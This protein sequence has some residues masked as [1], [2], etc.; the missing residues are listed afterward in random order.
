MSVVTYAAKLSKFS[1]FYKRYTPRQYMMAA[2]LALAMAAMLALGFM[3]GRN[4]A[5]AALRDCGE[6]VGGVH[7]SIANNPDSGGGCGA[8]S[9]E[10]LITDI[11][12][13]NP[14]DQAGVMA[15]FGL[16]SSSYDR[17]KNEAVMG[18]AKMNGDIV[19]DDEV[20]MKNAWS[21]GR[22]QFSYSQPYPIDGVGSYFKSAHT[23]VLQNEVPVMVLFDGSGAVETAVLTSCG[24]P[25]MGE[26]VISSAE[27]KDLR[28]VPVKE[29]ENTYSFTTDVNTEGLADIVKVEYFA[30]DEKFAEE[31]NPAT[32]VTKTFTENATVEARV[33]V[34]FPGGATKV[35]PSELCKE[36]V[37]VKKPEIKPAAVEKPKPQ[38]PKVEAVKVEEKLPVT[39]PES[40]LGIF[41]GTSLA[42]AIGH[43]LYTILRRK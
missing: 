24:N 39:G 17:F 34:R 35:L 37:E 4:S 20:V 14:D 6:E 26:K 3:I 27:C 33:T 11:N 5:A 21:I 32:P 2:I 18:V 31:E 40:A 9:P 36:V 43:R 10:E 23:D 38:Q 8:L 13:G 42:G 30:N 12:N 15:H 28:K 25:V 16:P 29:K 7:N 22:V 1:K 41:V 19:V